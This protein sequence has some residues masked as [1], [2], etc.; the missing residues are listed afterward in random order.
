MDPQ[1]SDDDIR[2]FTESNTQ[3]IT[4]DGGQVIKF[5]DW[6]VKK[7]A[8]LVKKRDTGHYLFLHYLG[9][10]TVI[11]EMERRFRISEQ[12]LKYLSVKLDDDADPEAFRKKAEEPAAEESTAPAETDAA[13]PPEESAPEP[14]GES[15]AASTASTPEEPAPSDTPPPSA[16][17]SDQD[18]AA[19]A[20]EPSTEPS[21]TTESESPERQEKE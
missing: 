19:A 5:A 16:E 10:P 14:A 3:L 18:S 9:T 13:A 8:Y 15:T 4:S 2:S 7:L 11:K 17:T 6:G 21:T 1:V 20:V 12:V